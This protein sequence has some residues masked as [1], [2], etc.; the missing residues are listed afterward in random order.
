MHVSMESQVPGLAR[1]RTKVFAKTRPLTE[2][3]FGDRQL[4]RSAPVEK[5]GS[6]SCLRGC[7]P[8]T[9]ADVS[10]LWRGMMY[11]NTEVGLMP[12]CMDGTLGT[13]SVREKQGLLHFELL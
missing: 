5:T 6:R 11:R 3:R 10:G 7:P 13:Q 8:V 12:C 9:L 2:L 1:P 4:D